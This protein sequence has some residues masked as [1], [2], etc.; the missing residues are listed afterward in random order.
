M[1]HVPSGGKSVKRKRYL[2]PHTSHQSSCHLKEDRK[3]ELK[4]YEY[5]KQNS[6]RIDLC[7]KNSDHFIITLLLQL[8][9][10]LAHLEGE[11]GLHCTK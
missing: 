10:M 6:Q 2:L 5:H 11:K 7:Q 1:L 8:F 3:I 9:L 4:M